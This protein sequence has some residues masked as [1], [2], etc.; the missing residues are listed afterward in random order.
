VCVNSCPDSAHPKSN[1]LGWAASL[2]KGLNCLP[3]RIALQWR[4]PKLTRRRS[5]DAP[6]ECWHVYYGDVLDWDD[7]DPI[8]QSN[9]TKRLGFR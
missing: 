5:V 2:A 1:W 4:M 3:A 9:D 7:R 8:W 6:D